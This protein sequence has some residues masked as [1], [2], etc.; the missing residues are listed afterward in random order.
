MKKIYTADRETGTFIEECATIEE[1][2]AKI[3]EYEEK[4]KVD[5]TYEK[6]FYAVVDSDHIT[7]G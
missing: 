3:K 4:D 6:D 1:A 2:K 5:G 7:I